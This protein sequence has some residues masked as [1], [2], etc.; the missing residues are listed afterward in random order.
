MSTMLKAMLKVQ[1]IA[2]RASFIIRRSN[3][4]SNETLRLLRY[5]EVHSIDTVLD[6]G[7]NKG[8]YAQALIE[9]GFKGT[10]YSFEALPEMH[11]KLTKLADKSGGQWLVAP[12][13]AISDTIGHAE[14]KITSAISSSSLLQPTGVANEMQ[15]IFKVRQTIN[16]PTTTLDQICTDLSMCSERI[17][18]KLDIQ[19]SEERALLGAQTILPRAIGVTIEMPLRSYYEGQASMRTLDRWLVERGF[20]LW[21]IDPEWRDPRTGRLDHINATYFRTPLN[22]ED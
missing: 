21:D 10:I 19:G 6:V 17:F 5:L 8:A 7:A 2:R 3:Y 9:G 1:D 14:F 22:G 12:Q 11:E 18:V 20:S 15:D 13:C 4:N 16:V